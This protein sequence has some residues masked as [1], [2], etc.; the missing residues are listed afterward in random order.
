MNLNNNKDQLYNKE[1]IIKLANEVK[2][3]MNQNKYLLEIIDIFNQQITTVKNII[4]IPAKIS[5]ARIPAPVPSALPL[6]PPMATAVS[7]PPLNALTNIYAAPILTAALII[8][9]II[10]ETDV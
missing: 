1:S 3:K 6:A 8:C 4:T 10:W 2:M 5:A 7:L 9:S